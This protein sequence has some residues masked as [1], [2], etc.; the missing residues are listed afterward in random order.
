MKRSLS[1]LIVSVFIAIVWRV[2]IELRGW[3]GLN[4]AGYHHI[5]VPLGGLIFAVWMWSQPVEESSR[6]KL[7]AMFLIWGLTA[8][9]VLEQVARV[10]F[11]SWLQMFFELSQAQVAVIVG[12]IWTAAILVLYAL[13]RIVIDLPGRVWVAGPLMWLGSWWFGFLIIT[14]LPE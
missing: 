6:R 8:A 14:I 10:C 13:Y 5:A 12:L 11:D 4:W 2:E 3:D 1:L 9:L 7:V